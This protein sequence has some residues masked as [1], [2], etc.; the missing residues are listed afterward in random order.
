MA[1]E[2]KRD[3]ATPALDKGLDILELLAREPRGLTKSEIARSLNRT[4]SEI[5]RMLLTLEAR[6]YISQPEKDRFS[7]TL[8]LFRLAQ[9]HPPT[10]RLL[11]E[12]LPV[13]QDLARQVHQ[14]CH[15]GVI[16]D[17][18]VVI[19]AQVNSPHVTGFYVKLGAVIDLTDA[20]T[21][22]VILAHQPTPV[23][24]QTLAR[25][26]E[27][28][29]SP[30]PRDFKHHLAKIKA[31]GME[32]RASYKVKGVTNI[33][34]PIFGGQGSAV[35][36]LAVPYIERTDELVPI[37]KIH[38]LMHAACARISTAIGNDRYRTAPTQL[39]AH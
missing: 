14:S 3:Y 34:H 6:G 30:I 17:A 8:Q 15:L 12:A 7:L 16:E 35:A 22:Q 38:T 13:M 4:I 19:L 24:D 2:K 26:T 37:P 20:A 21:G 39:S 33:S 25:W 11:A 31:Q 18:Q 9:E 5:F 1:S 27:R 36:A 32:Q 23:R 10:E 28:H 29:Q